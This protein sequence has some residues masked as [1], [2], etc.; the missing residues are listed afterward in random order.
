MKKALKFCVVF[1]TGILLLACQ[2]K[3]DDDTNENG[4]SLSTETV[5]SDRGVVFVPE[6][7]AEAETGYK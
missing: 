2:E 3:A 6:K 5:V 4:Q 1:L 7:G